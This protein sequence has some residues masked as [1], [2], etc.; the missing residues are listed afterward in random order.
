MKGLT[1]RLEP[2]T[3]SDLPRMARWFAGTRCEALLRGSSSSLM[4]TRD[5]SGI[6]DGAARAALVMGRDD[7]PVGVVHWWPI[8]ERA[9]EVGGAT[10]D[11][12][13]WRTGIGLE[14]AILMVDHL[15]EVAD[16]RRVEFTT[17]VHNDAT[18]SIGIDDDMT[19]EA[20][21]RDYL[22]SSNGTI[23]AIK[24]GLT[25]DE[26]S[27]PYA[28]YQPRVGRRI[29]IGRLTTAITELTKDIDPHAIARRIGAMT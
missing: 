29:D 21:C 9:Y 20:V 28:H 17:G 12:S 19:F 6:D 1:C 23:P 16:C 5:Y 18:L 11:E 7:R 25:R 8:G 15:F 4:R 27:Q 3:E 14:A 10:G 13:L 26:Y 22:Q 2:L 24:S